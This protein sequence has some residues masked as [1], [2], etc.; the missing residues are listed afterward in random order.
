MKIFNDLLRQYKNL[1]PYETCEETPTYLL[2]FFGIP[3]SLLFCYYSYEVSKGLPPLFEALDTTPISEWNWCY[4]LLF[5]E[6]GL[7]GFAAWL[8]GTRASA[9]GTVLKKRWKLNH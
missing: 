4:L 7:I 8:T 2:V 9:C 5:C 1:K 6:V 3:N